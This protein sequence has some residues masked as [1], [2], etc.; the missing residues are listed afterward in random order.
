ME[1]K[2]LSM[3]C[4]LHERNRNMLFSCISHK[5]SYFALPRNLILFIWFILKE[6]YRPR[7]QNYA[8]R[9]VF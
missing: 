3:Q 5:K 6:Q 4:N 9:N 7:W 2:I 8:M 1:R